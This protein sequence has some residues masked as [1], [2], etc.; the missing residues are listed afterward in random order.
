M[1]IAGLPDES[2]SGPGWAFAGPVTEVGRECAMYRLTRE[3]WL[4][5]RSTERTPY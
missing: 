3:D 4:T 5:S 2:A 1:V